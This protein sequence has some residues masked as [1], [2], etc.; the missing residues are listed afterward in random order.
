MLK[1]NRLYAPYIARELEQAYALGRKSFRGTWKAI[2]R[3]PYAES[4]PCHEEFMR[5][6]SDEQFDHPAIQVKDT[7][8]PRPHIY[9]TDE[10][11]DAA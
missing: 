7:P 9:R 8:F 5:G 10:R 11:G 6:R 1:T 2:L 4:S 3:Y